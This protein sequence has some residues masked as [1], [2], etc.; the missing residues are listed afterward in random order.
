MGLFPDLKGSITVTVPGLVQL[1][2]KC[3]NFCEK[4]KFTKEE[5]G[6]TDLNGCGVHILCYSNVGMGR[7]QPPFP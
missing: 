2:G 5:S 4:S 6:V 7:K 1:A 3:G